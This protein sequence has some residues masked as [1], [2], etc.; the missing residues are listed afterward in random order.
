MFK[1][2]FLSVFFSLTISLFV[3]KNITTESYKIIFPVLETYISTKGEDYSVLIGPSSY[4]TINRG[5]DLCKNTLDVL[6]NISNPCENY[7]CYVDQ[8]PIYHN[9]TLNLTVELKKDFYGQYLWAHQYCTLCQGKK[10][11]VTKLKDCIWYEKNYCKDIC[12]EGSICIYYDPLKS[13]ICYNPKTNKFN[14]REDA[15]HLYIYPIFLIY[16][17]DFVFLISSVVA[18][19]LIIS[20]LALPHTYDVYLRFKTNTYTNLCKKVLHFFPSQ[21]LIHLSFILK[22]TITII[23][24]I[25]SFLISSRSRLSALREIIFVQSIFFFMTTLTFLVSEWV[26]IVEQSDGNKQEIQFTWKSL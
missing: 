14:F 16:G 22:N 6:K 10:E 20:L 2:T 25:F 19:F 7:F 26:N 13:N 24:T 9:K 5:E 11:N 4:Y 17:P 1:L 15:L 18:L 23:I 3:E 8:P 12:S 21:T